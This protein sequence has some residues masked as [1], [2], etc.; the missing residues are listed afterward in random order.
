[1]TKELNRMTQSEFFKLCKWLEENKSTVVVPGTDK[2]QIALKATVALGM[3]ITRANIHA[4]FGTLEI[5]VP[6]SPKTLEQKV[7]I[8]ARML[9]DLYKVANDK[10]PSE[11][12]EIVKEK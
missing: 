5:N 10:V 11:L 9:A 2:Q 7:D 6:G 8:I 1:M 3:Q 4:A 12:A